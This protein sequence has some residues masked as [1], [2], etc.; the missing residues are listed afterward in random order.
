VFCLF[1]ETAQASI[2]LWQNGNACS[3]KMKGE[4]H[5]PSLR[6][7]RRGRKDDNFNISA[8]QPL[9]I[10]KVIEA[11]DESQTNVCTRDKK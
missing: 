4:T 10:F 11:D 2:D 9:E 3:N 8:Q 5:K 1:Y 6:L 7:P